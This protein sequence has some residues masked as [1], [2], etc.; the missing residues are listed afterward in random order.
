M[1]FDSIT[2]GLLVAAAG[3][4]ALALSG[5]F[6]F[7]FAILMITLNERFFGMLPYQFGDYDLIRSISG[8]VLL[9]L[10]I[11][12]QVIFR[13]RHFRCG[14][15]NSGA[16]YL[17][18]VFAIIGV[19]VFSTLW[20]GIYIYHQP[21]KALIFQP[22]VFFYYFLYVY[23]C[24]FSPD[25]NQ[26]LRFLDFVVVLALMITV[27][28]V[29]DAFIF[30]QPYLLK[31]ANV[32]ERIGLVRIIAF[33]TGILWAY[34]YSLASA[35]EEQYPLRRKILFGFGALIFL[36]VINFIM[37]DR[38]TMLFCFVTTAIVAW[39][40]KPV[41]KAIILWSL[42]LLILVVMLDFEN[43]Y[44]KSFFGDIQKLTVSEAK[45]KESGI[46]VRL[47]AMEFY[48]GHFKKTYGLGFGV[49]G[50]RRELQNP[51]S[52]GLDKGYNLN[53]L[54][55]TGIIFKFGVPG[56]LLILVAIWKMLR[57]TT[58]ILRTRDPAIRSIIRGI[59]FTIIH[60]VIIFPLTTFLFYSG[61]AVYF[62]IMFFLVDRFRSI[63]SEETASVET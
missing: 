33:G 37:I 29:L 22:V 58:M 11:I 39:S 17:W 49:L 46:G 9:L 61:K 6:P 41:K 54:S 25:K 59:R 47:K 10:A 43:L 56:L 45:T 3:S 2:I 23:L 16:S 62:A 52:I 20:G 42:A 5:W 4:A 38:Q 21:L 63:V 34:Y 13:W 55:L 50:S 48:Y 36:I 27:C 60:M 32:S 7:A 18:L 44:N 53:D 26:I 15:K 14:I 31:Y 24:F 12:I 40:M 30:H 8:P 57:D 35:D 28:M 19:V 51:V 1:G